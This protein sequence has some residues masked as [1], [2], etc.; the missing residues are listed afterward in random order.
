MHAAR[1]QLNFAMT[2]WFSFESSGSENDVTT[3][4]GQETHFHPREKHK[5]V[6]AL[7]II[8]QKTCSV[9][10]DSQVYF[11]LGDGKG[12]GIQEIDGYG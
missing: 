5:A 8:G 10:C 6:H 12:G 11:V 3:I 4:A 1:W 7:L 9:P 2:Y